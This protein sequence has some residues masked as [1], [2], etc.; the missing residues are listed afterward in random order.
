MYIVC[1]F[2][3]KQTFYLGQHRWISIVH[4]QTQRT[5]AN[6]K[7]WQ[8]FTS[9]RIAEEFQ[10]TPNVCVS[11]SCL[12]VYT[13]HKTFSHFW[14]P[15]P[16]YAKYFEKQ[17]FMEKGEKGRNRSRT[18]RRIRW[19][20]TAQMLP[21]EERIRKSKTLGPPA[22][23]PPPPRSILGFFFFSEN[24]ARVQI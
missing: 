2:L 22:S 24:V 16:R 17:N 13:Q 18:F 4:G 20:L 6:F 1:R 11:I 5:M 14:F 12:Y 7:N 23:P 15:D 10:L 9:V 3:H 8:N 21:N 19:Y